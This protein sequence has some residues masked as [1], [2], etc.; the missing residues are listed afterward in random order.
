MTA[1]VEAEG[2]G[3]DEEA[4]GGKR[5]RLGKGTCACGVLNGEDRG[6]SV[7][8]KPVQN[9][10]GKKAKNENLPTPFKENPSTS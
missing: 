5:K 2:G 3:E 10:Q 4:Q 9:K 1:N 8:E 6:T 7:S